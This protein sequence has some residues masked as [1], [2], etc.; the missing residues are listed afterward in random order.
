MKTKLV[1]S[2]LL[3][4]ILADAAYSFVQY[5]RQPLDGDMSSIVLPSLSYSRV[6]NDPFGFAVLRNNEVYPAT[7]RFFSHVFMFKYFNTAPSL[8]QTFVSP[9]DSVYLSCALFKTTLHLLI[10]FLVGAYAC[11]HT[12]FWRRDFILVAALVSPLMQTGGYHEFMGIVS[13]SISYSFFYALPVGLLLLFFLPYYLSVLYNKQ[14]DTSIPVRAG[15]ISLLFILSFSGPLIPGVVLLLTVFIFSYRLFIG[16]KTSVV[17]SSFSERIQSMVMR[18]DKRALFYFLFFSLVCAYSFFIGRNNSEN[19]WETISISERYSRLPSGLGFLFFRQ[20]G[21]SLLLVFIIINTMILWKHPDRHV[22]QRVFPVLK[23][24]LIFSIAYL[25]LLPLGGYR[26]YRPVILRYDT[27]MPVT[28]CMMICFALTTGVVLPKLS[29][30]FKNSY[31]TGLLLF[32]FVYL[33][34]DR[35]SKFDNACERTLIGEIAASP[36][37][38]V[39]IKSDCA[40]LSWKKV[41]DY[42][43]SITNVLVLQRWGV[44]K[45]FKLYYEE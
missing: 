44:L 40:I 15:L 4:F 2:V 10:I 11:G 6:L 43:T 7:N 45:D 14:T 9:L 12:R 5:Y 26:E 33:N 35:P 36:Q 29:G 1:Y 37:K 8:L 24:S 13:K 32:S 27:F 31:I 23:W 20:M 22:S 39:R 41:D 18:P 3:F 25:L 19:N 16:D 42:R 17:R 34:A 38:I 30:H 28:I 21:L